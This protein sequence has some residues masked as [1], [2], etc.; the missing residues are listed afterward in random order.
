MST[1]LDLAKELINRKSISPEDNG[2]QQLLAQRLEKLGFSIEWLP[3]E[4]VTNLWATIGDDGPLFVFAGHTDV[5]PTGPVSE[6]LFDPFQ[7]TE[8]EEFLYGRGAADMKSSLAAMIT[9]TEKFLES[10]QPKARLGFLITSDEEDKAI[11]GTRRVMAEFE[12]R[13]LFIDYCLVGEPSSTNKLG[14]TIKVGR[15]GSLNGKLRV[16]GVKGHVAYPHLASNPI[17]NAL[18]ALHALVESTWDEGNELFPPTSFQISN[19][20]GGV[21]VNNV[22]PETMDLDFNFRYSTELDSETLIKRVEDVLTTA[23]L[24]FDIQWHLSGE[25]FLTTKT[26]LIDAICTSVA[27]VT[28]LSPECSTAGG[29]SDGRF[30]APT[31]TEVVELGPC[32]ATIHKINERVRITDIDQLES[33][34]LRVLEKLV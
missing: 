23:Q 22:I 14:D 7:A 24:N 5:V 17:H 20:K 19:I 13:K 32:N 25:P 27:Q 9:A 12:K 31:G 34:Y 28:G 10:K 3:F 4:D 1:A 16:T 29:T 18:G 11:N 15:R 21:G 8:H 6:W 2:C 33:I 26:T 30:I